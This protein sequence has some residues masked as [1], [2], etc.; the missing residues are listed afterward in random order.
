MRH[1][2]IAAAF[3]PPA[4]KPYANALGTRCFRGAVPGGEA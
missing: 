4:R 1:F 2:V 3:P